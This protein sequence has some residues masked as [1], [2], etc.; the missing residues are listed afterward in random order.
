MKVLSNKHVIIAMIVAPILAVLAYLATDS[1][2][3]EKPSAAKTGESYPLAA[4]SN[5]RYQSGKCSL[6]NGDVELVIR[7]E[8]IDESYVVLRLQASHAISQA[9][10]AIGEA[11][12]M[13]MPQQMNAKTNA[14]GEA[15]LLVSFD[16]P[17]PEQ[18][19]IQLAVTIERTHYYAEVETIFI[20]FET[21]YSRDNFSP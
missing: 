14:E 6:F 8:R 2:V 5:C 7:A 3:S 12:K 1:V 13:P 19:Q 15:E 21:I 11:D 16:M 10:I 4:R 17:K 18:K 9:L 20:D